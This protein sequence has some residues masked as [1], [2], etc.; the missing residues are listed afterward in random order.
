MDA[1]TSAPRN[2]R[3]HGA[4]RSLQTAL[5]LAVAA[6]FLV[7]ALA[8][9][10]I[11]GWTA[12]TRARAALESDL[13]RYTQVL[14][15]ALRAPLWELSL[16]NT[17]AIVRSIVDD[18]RFVSVIV[19]DAASGQVFVDIEPTRA[20]PAQTMQ[21]VGAVE[22]EGQLVGTFE[23]QMSLA[24]YL[25]AD[26][27]QSRDNLLQLAM[28]LGLSLA[29]IV[30][31]LRHRLTGPL[32]KL[33]EA[34]E[35]IAQEDLK[36]P[37]SLDYRDELGHVAK[38]MDGMRQR[39]LGVFDE[40]RQNN[41]VLENLNDLASDWRW[42]QDANFRFTYFSPG[43][44]RIVGIDPEA[45]IG[46]TRWDG[47]TTLSDAEWAEHRACLAA[48]QPFRDFEFG[49]LLENGENVYLSIAGHP[50]YLPD[51]SFAGYRG[52][53]K[54]VT[55]RKR[56]EQELVNSEARFA[57]LF[58][59]SPVAL[60]VTSETDGFH[61]TRWNQAW[62]A[63][64]AYPPAV[65]RGHAG[66]DFGLWLDPAQRER[67]IH[68]A[69]E[70]GGGSP[71]EVLMRRAD[72]EQ[73]L[74]RVTGRFIVAGGQRQ[75]L[76]AY[77]DVTEARRSEQSIREL[78]AGLE[79]RI[80][81][82][83]AELAA[84]KLAAEQASL[85]KST[86]LANMSHEIRTPMNAIIG[87]NH[88][89]RREVSDPRPLARLDK[90]GNAA[91]HLLGIINDILDLSKIEAGKLALDNIDFSLDR[92]LLGV[93]D[94]VR[95]RAAAKDLE[96]IVDTDHLPPSLHGDG[97]RLG[98]IILNFVSNAIKFTEQGQVLL[99]CRIIESNAD[100]LLIR[101]EVSD[102]GTGL[103]PEQQA[104]LFAAFE[105]GDV[106]TTR[107]H[108]GTGLGLVISKRLAELMGGQVG[109]ESEVGHGSTFWAQLPLQRGSESSWPQ[110]PKEL[111]RTTRVL[112]VDDLPDARE[113]LLAILATLGLDAEGVA[114]G[115]QA[116]DAVLRSDQSARPFDL[117]LIDWRMPGLDGFA[118]ARRLGE[119]ALQ[120]RPAL[121]LV[122]AAATVPTADELAEAGFCGFLAK[123][124][125]SSTLYDGLV[126]T[127]QA[128]K[129]AQLPRRGDAES[130]LYAY[131]HAA[132]LLVEDNPVNQD[133]AHDLLKNVGFVVETA[134]DGVEAL[135]M[136]S[137]RRYDLI[138]MDVQMPRMDGLEATR[139]I[140]RLPGYQA[141]PIL[142][143]TANAFSADRQ[144]CADAGMNDHIV[145]PVDPARL[146]AV[147][148]H[149]LHCSGVEPVFAERRPSAA[150]LLAAAGPAIDWAN[151][152]QRYADR[153]EFIGK[154]LGSA[155]DYYGDTPSE[156]A[157]CIAAEDHE[158]IARIAHGLKS[159]GGN[160]MARRL[161]HIAKQTDEAV[162][163]RDAAA[164]V[165][166]DELRQ[167]LTALLDEAR[168]WLE[169]SGVH[170]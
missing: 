123:P 113:P 84:A 133:V 74:V 145:K 33:T 170:S 125:T 35:R 63:S 138:L 139:Q 6:A 115:Q 77:D 75:L 104:R 69:G 15:A 51:G 99:R 37:I 120:R 18:R 1:P 81:E 7:P 71:H 150:E 101:F 43:I 53:G 40:L 94:M 147:I 46:S 73:R 85:A 163:R 117:V 124:I 168:Q 5:L 42:E 23:L 146:Y 48:H 38:A 19:R 21:R 70:P 136:A 45:S 148:E 14:T 54:N 151:L 78:N 58:E 22:H 26:Q 98:Q 127:L 17:E 89:L 88:L 9:Y 56:W 10:L 44:A 59:L 82:R 50:V 3:L 128:T 107:K 130:R 162:R 121:T 16:S 137:A 142:A 92:V 72:G 153:P 52:T 60:S 97:N 64:F 95:E 156:L 96:L 41:E 29:L 31:I 118:T 109:C 149:W 36:T 141:V 32:H 62:F 20:D 160:L 91:Q 49:L 112:V 143:M 80:A 122:S 55:E 105:Q 61:S 144:N 108:G 79:A 157:R 132:L 13:A 66:T 152:E 28:A 12:E 131:R 159:T 34:A 140:R 103:T 154:L 27:R 158:S 119:L 93:A 30:F 76:T 102:T 165:L 166:A 24:P 87:L 8:L 25:E 11:Q 155:L 167:A 86:F 135:S 68:R 111:D 134:A 106:T 65:A 164:L 116:L 57:S 2:S 39:L 100:S 67:L 169:K 4:A 83:T 110:L 114:T 47:K 126:G 90:I 161:M 129:S